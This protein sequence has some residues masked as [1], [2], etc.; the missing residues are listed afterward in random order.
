MTEARDE[1]GRLV[2]EARVFAALS[3]PFDPK[4]A[5]PDAAKDD[6]KLLVE[7]ASVLASGCDTN[8]DHSN[9][10]LLRTSERRYILASL[11]RDGRLRAA[12]TRRRSAGPDLETA[13]LLLALEGS[14]TFAPGRIREDLD[15]SPSEQRLERIV[16]AL[17]RAGEVAP[18]SVLLAYGDT[19]A[20]PG[21]SG[22]V[23][24]VTGIQ[25]SRAIHRTLPER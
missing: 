24:A 8:P 18:G 14:D 21:G 25:L 23:P 22:L 20:A 9:D 11:D 12:I 4:Q 7:V 13:D 15:H 16:V 2:E 5:L 1:V 6:P 10:W 19:G 17:D 3:G